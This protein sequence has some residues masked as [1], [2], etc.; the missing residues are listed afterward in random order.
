VTTDDMGERAETAPLGELMLAIDVTDTLRRR[1]E[2]ADK[3][4]PVAALKDI[5]AALGIG[6]S[7]TALADGIAAYRSGRF[8][9]APPTR[10]LGAMLARLYVVRRHWLAGALSIGL[11]LAIALGGYFLVYRPYRDAQIEAAKVELA[12]T[13]P[14]QIDAAYQ[15]IFEETKV[16]QAANDAAVL[17]DKGKAAAAKGDRSGAESAL[18]ELIAIRD[19][20]RE[21]FRL[22][23]VDKPSVKWGFWTFP[24]D[25]SDATNYYLV[26]EARDSGGKILSVPVRNEPNGRIETVTM[27]GVRV[28]EEVYRAVEADKN[29]DG[30]IEH[31]LVGVKQ[32]G[33]L[34]PAYLIAVLG[35]ALTRW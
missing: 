20:L 22:G 28:P 31:N 35:G 23:I 16:Q 33:F 1:P 29:D 15:A 14:T 26:V 11:M 4:D 6:A 7:A 17:R 19:T 12:Q 18:T 24:E 34:E 13:I 32:Y 5:Y 10:G 3:P 25:N 2:L 27:W 30:V 8:V 9:Y 21:D